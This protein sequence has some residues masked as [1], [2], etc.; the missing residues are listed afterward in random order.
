MRRTLR[1][2]CSLLLG[3]A[4]LASCTGRNEARQLALDQ[5]RES[6]P[7]AESMKVMAVSEPDSA[8]GTNYFTQKETLS[9]IKMMKTVTD[10]IMART[11]GM[12]RLDPNDYYVLSLADRQ[13]RASN[14]IRD[15]VFRSGKKGDWSGWKVRIDYQATD[16]TGTKYRAERWALIDKKAKHVIRTFEL[17]LP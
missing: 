12:T 15:I 9:M 3:L 13:M 8:F 17:P 2:T 14:E 7:H 1:L 4:L 11:D 6:L 5:L 10:T 16:H